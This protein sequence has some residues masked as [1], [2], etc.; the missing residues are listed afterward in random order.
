[1]PIAEMSPSPIR[2]APYNGNGEVTLTKADN[3]DWSGWNLVGNPFAQT[4]YISKPFYKMNQDGTALSATTSTGAIDAMEGIFVNAENDGETLTFSTSEPGQQA[5][6]L[7]LNVTQKRSV[8]IDRAIISFGEKSLLPK[9]TLN[10]NDTKVYIPQ[11]TEDYAIVNA[12]SEGELPINF[13]TEENGTYTLAFS[14]EGVTF[15][16]L[17]LIDNMTGTD[18]DLM[19]TPSYSFEAR[20]TDYA[21]RFRLVFSTNG[22]TADNDDVFAFFSNDKLVVLNE[23]KATLQV[24]DVMGRVLCTEQINGDAEVNMNQPAGIYSLRLINSE[25]VK[26]QKIV[27]K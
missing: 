9:F 20:K 2:G 18:V 15:N 26:T 25:I 17:H 11:G 27:V 12:M 22:N 7:V 5:A 6:S 13:K 19:Q 14:N 4:A 21:S 10:P 3:V 16:Y 23:G 24:V 1:M 8:A